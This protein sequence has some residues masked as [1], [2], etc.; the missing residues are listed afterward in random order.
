M[1]GCVEEDTQDTA[2]L[3]LIDLSRLEKLNTGFNALG[4]EAVTKAVDNE[5][6]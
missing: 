3:S 5:N 2:T 6:F 4:I 1:A